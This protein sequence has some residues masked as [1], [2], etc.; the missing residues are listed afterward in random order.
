MPD[1]P[2]LDPVEQRVL[3]ALLEKQRAVPD[4]YPL[5]LNA[6]RAA[7]NQSTSRDPVVSYDETTIVD[8]LGRLRDR[9]LVRF[10]KPTMVRV[11]KYHQRLE[12]HL[13]L[14]AEQAALITVLL[15][16]GAQTAGELRPRTERL[17]PFPI[18]RRSKAFSG[19]W[20]PRTRRWCESWNA[21]PGNT[22]AAGCICSART[23]PRHAEPVPPVD[24]EQVL[25]GGAAA[26]DRKVAAEYDRL[27][28]Q[29]ADALGDELDGK[30][31]DRWLL[32]RIAGEA[33]AVRDWTSAA[34]RATSRVSWPTT[35]S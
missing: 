27:A 6:L 32:A 11:V 1:H 4:T 8:A 35:A 17:L 7:C 33:G 28:E 10:V 25:S 5:S 21:N 31:F 14:D 9:E 13:G 22:T 23:S 34:D 30:S 18:A 3:G 2:V 12:E 20:P 24:R 29:Y 26:R 16:R 15:L 19:R